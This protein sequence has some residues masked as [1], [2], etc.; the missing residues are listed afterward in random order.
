MVD[1]LPAGRV[2]GDPATALDIL[3]T[4]VHLAGGKMRRDRV[5]DGVNA[6]SAWSGEQG[7]A[8][9]TLYFY[10]VGELPLGLRV[11][12]WK[13]HVA[14]TSR[15]LYDLATD[16]GESHDLAADYPQIVTELS[17]RVALWQERVEVQ[18]AAEAGL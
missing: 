11:G 3:P 6:W 9:R 8:E 2:M 14:G 17:S 15:R 18:K 7:P 16:P 1:Q 12:E 10:V 5:I 13:M 4:F